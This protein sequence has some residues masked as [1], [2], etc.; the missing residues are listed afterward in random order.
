MAAA[1][2]AATSTGHKTGFEPLL[3][4]EDVS[5]CQIAEVKGIFHAF[6]PRST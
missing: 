1:A 3:R 5:D 4:I 2:A 6:S